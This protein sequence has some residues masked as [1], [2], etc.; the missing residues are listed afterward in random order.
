MAHLQRFTIRLYEP[1][2]R[3]ILNYVLV[4]LVVRNIFIKIQI[5]W[6]YLF[7]KQM[8]NKQEKGYTLENI[9]KDLESGVPENK[10]INCLLY[11]SP[12]PRD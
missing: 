5:F 9:Y 8:I 3:N 10:S 12:S 4:I 6:V 1:S 2:Q 11:T 7:D